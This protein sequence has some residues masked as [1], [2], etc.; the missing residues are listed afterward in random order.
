[1]KCLLVW[2]DFLGKIPR[3]LSSLVADLEFS[4]RSAEFLTYLKNGI[5]L[6]LRC[7]QIKKQNFFYFEGLSL[8]FD[9][10]DWGLFCIDFG[11]K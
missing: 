2:H 7:S 6:N 11:I 9:A 8:G 3:P 5:S 1:M 10:R 4:F